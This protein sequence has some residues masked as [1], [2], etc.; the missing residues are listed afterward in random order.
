MQAIY[1]LRGVRHLDICCVIS[2]SAS[3]WPLVLLLSILLSSCACS[4]DLPYV[5][6]VICLLRQMSPCL[7][8]VDWSCSISHV[9][10]VMY[11]LRH[12]RAW[13]PLILFRRTS[14]RPPYSPPSYP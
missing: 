1:T 3:A 8:L 2:D 7:P 11:L 13:A 14:L 12:L 4:I 5:L 10:C 6:C 9:L